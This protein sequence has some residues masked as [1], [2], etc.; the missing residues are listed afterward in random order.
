M[1]PTVNPS[2]CPPWPPRPVSRPGNHG[3]RPEPAELPRQARSPVPTQRRAQP[4]PGRRSG[5]SGR[6]LGET[7]GSASR[8]GRAIDLRFWPGAHGAEAGVVAEVEVQMPPK[9]AVIGH[10][11]PAPAADLITLVITLPAELH[12]VTSVALAS[13]AVH[14]PPDGDETE[15]ASPVVGE[16]NEAGRHQVDGLPGPP[17]PLHDP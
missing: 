9:R 7:S 1:R 4:V 2:M 5:M 3:G 6:P 10:Y 12:A 14:P 15:L 17:G 16:L 8:P 11:R 13:A